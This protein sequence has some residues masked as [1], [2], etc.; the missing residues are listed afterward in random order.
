MKIKNLMSKAVGLFVETEPGTDAPE[1][2]TDSLV[3]DAAP[4]TPRTIEQI[5]AAAP[6]PK[7][8]EIQVPKESAEQPIAVGGKPDFNRIYN[9]AGVPVVAFGA[10]EVLDVIHSL[11][12]DLAIDVR[13]KA[14]QSTLGAMGKAMG[15]STES[16]V[17]DA[18]RKLKALESYSDKLQLRAEEF[19]AATEASIAE[20]E[21]QIAAHR[22][23][24]DENKQLLADA[25]AACEAES[26]R[27]DD[28]LEFFSLD[29]SPSKNAPD[30]TSH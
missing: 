8:E 27:I 6:G 13:R 19:A 9:Q 5:V 10:N 23:T 21:K 2:G 3:L 14:V 24:L 28:I 4:V 22:Q 26:D 11:P 16:V 17:T 25:I 15:V 29:I 1:E 20:L 30:Q 12:A 7:L 18:T